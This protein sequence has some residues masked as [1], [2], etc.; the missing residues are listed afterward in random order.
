MYEWIN[1]VTVI[2]SI[3]TIIGTIIATRHYY[4]QQCISRNQLIAEVLNEVVVPLLNEIKRYESKCQYYVGR[5]DVSTTTI[6]VKNYARSEILHRRFVAL[7]KKYHYYEEFQREID[8]FNRVQLDLKKKVGALSSTLANMLQ[9]NKRIQV[10][11]EEKVKKAHPN[12]K[13]T[14]SCNV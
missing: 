5:V 8:E 14:I 12:W 13:Y 4:T 7:L 6:D 1:I 3:V 2:A 10:L 9:G 11:W